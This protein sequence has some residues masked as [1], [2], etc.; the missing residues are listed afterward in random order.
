MLIIFS[1]FP[2]TSDAVVHYIKT[3]APNSDITTVASTI[4][5]F[6]KQ[7]KL[8]WKKS[9]FRLEYFK[10]HN[11]SW[12]SKVLII[13]DKLVLN[14][15]S[16][17]NIDTIN[18]NFALPNSNMPST[19]NYRVLDQIPSVEEIQFSQDLL[20]SYKK[21]TEAKNRACPPIVSSEQGCWVEIQTMLDE[22]TAR[23]FQSLS[24]G[25][26]ELIWKMGMDSTSG[27]NSF[28]Q[29]S[30]EEINESTL[31]T[32]SLVPLVLEYM[33]KQIM[34]FNPVC[35]STRFCR[36]LEISYTKET[37]PTIK[38]KYDFYQ[39]KI[40]ELSSTVIKD[41]HIKHKIFWTM[42]DGKC[43]NCITNVDD[44]SCSTCGS[45]ISHIQDTN[46]SFIPVDD[47]LKFG[48]PIL[49][50]KLNTLRNI[51]EVAYKLPFSDDYRK[52]QWLKKEAKTKLLKDL[53]EKV[54]D[55]K[56]RGSNWFKVDKIVQGKG[57]SNTGNVARKF[58]SQYEKISEI[59]G[60]MQVELT[61]V[62]P[63]LYEL[64]NIF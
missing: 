44:K 51:L 54:K 25:S 24:P 60:K 40:K 31:L 16:E 12:L 64:I 33:T 27:L 8:R 41:S 42:L 58:F 63:S 14:T 17:L 52:M 18:N 28:H 62:L 32:I 22:T 23:L 20:P 19:S 34:W 10:K 4:Y 45:P 7:Y 9:N 47:N 3:K 50:S 53:D 29:K 56:N 5:E 6:V 46:R 2:H 15:E 13:E 61:A 49:H 38:E 59:T 26:Y 35:G 36:P 21:I 43:V 55:N 48:I 1:H 30:N 39:S 37:K 57:T 11:F